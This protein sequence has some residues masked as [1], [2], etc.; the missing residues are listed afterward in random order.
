MV[1]KAI[2][3]QLKYYSFFFD[4]MGKYIICWTWNFITKKLYNYESGVT[5]IS[6][7]N[8]RAV[9]HVLQLLVKIYRRQITPMLVE[10]IVRFS[11]L[12]SETKCLISFS[13]FL[14]LSVYKDVSTQKKVK[15]NIQR[16]KK[17]RVLEFFICF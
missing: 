15:R 12:S 10:R 5:M 14:F 1:K 11:L 16:E 3:P 17:Y 9:V 4:R 6:P 8:S 2:M 13:T 7:L